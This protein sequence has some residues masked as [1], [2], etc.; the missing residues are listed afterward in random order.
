MSLVS[1]MGEG[2]RLLTDVLDMPLLMAR[3]R[4]AEAHREAVVAFEPQEQVVQTDLVPDPP[5]HS[6]GVVED[7][8]P[9]HP[10]D[11]T[12]DVPEPLADALGRLPAERLDEAAVAVGEAQTEVLDRPF[13]AV[14]DDIGFPEVRLGLTRRPDKLQVARLIP[15]LPLVQRRDNLRA[16]RRIDLRVGT[17]VKASPEGSPK[18]EDVA[19]FSFICEMERREE[20]HRRDLRPPTRILS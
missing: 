16:D 14:L 8:P 5:S 2:A 20:C 15:P 17:A 1:W 3:I 7:D 18:G 19:F 6:A 12:E 4:V 11:V 13:D 9:R 10:A